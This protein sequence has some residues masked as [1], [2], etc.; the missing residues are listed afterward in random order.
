[1]SH[2]PKRRTV[3]NISIYGGEAS[4]SRIFTIASMLRIEKNT[5]TGRKG[6][7]IKRREGKDEKDNW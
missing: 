2:N 1:M 5:I 6:E 4:V 3:H 7:L